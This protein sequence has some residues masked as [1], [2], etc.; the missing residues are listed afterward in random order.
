MRSLILLIAA[1]GGAVVAQHVH[2]P[3]GVATGAMTTVTAFVL[4]YAV[5]PPERRRPG[6]T[7]T[8]VIAL[9]PRKKGQR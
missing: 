8:S 3:W 5:C 2:G 7:G 1:V 6:A 9:A 4:S